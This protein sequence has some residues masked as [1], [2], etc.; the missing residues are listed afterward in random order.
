MR[1]VVGIDRDHIEGVVGTLSILPTTLLA[2]ARL[3][4]KNITLSDYVKRPRIISDR[5]PAYLIHILD[6]VLVGIKVQCS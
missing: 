3:V 5:L 4:K 2:T 1:S 6:V